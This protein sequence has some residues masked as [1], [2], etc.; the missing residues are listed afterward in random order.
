MMSPS[1]VCLSLFLSVLCWHLGL[2]ME[3]PAVTFGGIGLSL[4]AGSRV[5]KVERPTWGLVFVLLTS[6]AFMGNQV[7]EDWA[8]DGSWPRRMVWGQVSFLVCCS[9]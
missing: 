7:L 6:G 2:S 9:I 5:L 3:I 8:L 1:T 4:L